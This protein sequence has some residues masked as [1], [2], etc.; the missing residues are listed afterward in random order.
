[1]AKQIMFPDFQF[2]QAAMFIQLKQFESGILIMAGSAIWAVQN[3]DDISV[4][5]NLTIYFMVE[6][7]GF[8]HLK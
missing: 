2:Q 8:V 4:S 7:I 5:A 3:P 1:M 6:N